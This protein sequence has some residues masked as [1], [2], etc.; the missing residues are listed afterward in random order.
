[1]SWKILKEHKSTAIGGIRAF[2]K[3]SYCDGV[4]LITLEETPFCPS[5]SYMVWGEKRGYYYSL[6]QHKLVENKVTSATL[7][8]E[9]IEDIPDDPLPEVVDTKYIL[10]D[11]T[12]GIS[13]TREGFVQLHSMCAGNHII[14]NLSPEAALDVAH[15]LTRQAM[16]LK[17]AKEAEEWEDYSYEEYFS[18][19]QGMESL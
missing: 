3:P 11:S 17:R 14:L 5:P 12:L 15:D 19:R 4:Y 16:K 13:T 8:A 7:I 2:E 6:A 10:M 9:Y 18:D 1:M